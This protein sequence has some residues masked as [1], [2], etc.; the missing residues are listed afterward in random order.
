MFSLS[1]RPPLYRGVA[2][3]RRRVSRRPQRAHTPPC[4]GAWSG[5]QCGKPAVD[6][7]ASLHFGFYL[8]QTLAFAGFSVSNRV[9]DYPHQIAYIFA[10]TST[11]VSA[12]NQVFGFFIFDGDFD[13]Q[14]VNFLI[15]SSVCFHFSCSFYLSECGSA[16][17]ANTADN[18]IIHLS[19]KVS[20]V[21]YGKNKKDFNAERSGEKS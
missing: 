11:L 15:P 9:C 12:F 7:R 17:P 18:L 13:A 10:G 4:G 1:Q 3:S 19:G 14:S 5:F 6:R 16:R 21:L 8:E 20:I 2:Q